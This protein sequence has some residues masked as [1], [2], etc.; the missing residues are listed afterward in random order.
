MNKQHQKLWNDMVEIL[1]NNFPKLNYKNVSK[2]SS[3]NRSQALVMLSD[4]K[5]LFDKT[6]EQKDTK[7]LGLETVIQGQEIMLRSLGILK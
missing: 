6:L 3:N 2:P 4:L 5:I 7:I 1:E